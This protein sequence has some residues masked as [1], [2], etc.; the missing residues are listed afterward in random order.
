MAKKS[1]EVDSDFSY[2]GC[3]PVERQ[4]LEGARRFVDPNLDEFWGLECFARHKVLFDYRKKAI[5]V[6]DQ[7]DDIMVVHP[8]AEYPLL[9]SNGA[10]RLIIPM[11]I[12]GVERRMV[13][14]SGACIANYITES[15]ATTGTEAGSVFDDHPDLG[16]YEVKLFNLSVDIGGE[17]V[18]IPL[19]IQPA[20]VDRY[21]QADGAIGVIGLGLYEKFQVLVDCPNRRLVLG[22]YE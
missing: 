3:T 11:K 5:M 9:R 20:K 10:P 17:S 21:V 19:G 7:G 12:A 8:I 16:R 15:I 6:A 14:D 22:K 1:Y 13:F 2:R 4:H 18:D